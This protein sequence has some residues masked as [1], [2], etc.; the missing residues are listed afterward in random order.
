[1]GPPHFLV[2]EAHL[3]SQELLPV[4]VGTLLIFQR[5]GHLPDKTATA[6]PHL[7]YP[8]H[9]DPTRTSSLVVAHLNHPFREGGP[10][11]ILHLPAFHLG[12]TDLYLPHLEV[13][14]LDT[15][16]V[17]LHLPIHLQA[18]AGPL[19]PPLQEG[20]LRSP[21]TDPHH[22]RLLPAVIGHLCPVIC[23]LLH[24]Q[25]TPS[26][27]P[28]LL[29][30]RHLVGGLLLSH[31]ADLALRLSRPPRLEVTTTVLLVCPKGT[32]HSTSTS[33]ILYP[34]HVCKRITVKF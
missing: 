12:G 13:L 32:A 22:H 21:T 26:H 2:V 34:C 7:P 28:P 16:Q 24:P 20:D 15:D 1:M 30:D 33:F 10:A 11:L 27:L 6:L 19:F 5:V 31:Q 4:T 8:T 29:L 18:A 25:S 17:F 9:L 14:R 23:P 3:N